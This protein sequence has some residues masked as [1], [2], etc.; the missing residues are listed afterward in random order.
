MS[1][2]IA[3]IA[4]KV[5]TSTATISRALNG[6]PGVSTELRAKILHAAKEM[7]YLPNISARGLIT[8]KTKIAA[9]VVEAKHA[10]SADPFY[11]S[12]LQGIQTELA[13]NSYHVILVGYNNEEENGQVWQ[14]AREQK[15]DGFIFAGPDINVATILAI[16][17]AGYPVV[18]VD[19][20]LPGTKISSISID[21]LGGAF[22][23]V[24]HLI[25]HGHKKITFL[26]GASGWASTR[27]RLDGY[28]TALR[29]NG[30]DP[31][32]KPLF[33][34]ATT[35]ETG[36]S[37]MIS[38]L[39]GEVRPTAVFAVNDA[40]AIGAM[41]AIHEAGLQ[42]PEDIAVAGFDDVIWS[43]YSDP[44]LT[45]ASVFKEKLGNQAG[46]H[47]LELIESPDEPPVKIEVSTQ[48]VIRR[49][50][51]CRGDRSS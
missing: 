30:I 6:L 26:G 2:T 9:F 5:G 21:N 43:A 20:S 35:I 27:E 24:E 23:V 48:L 51:G 37:G 44:P 16:K 1:V 39:G 13:K 18:L 31:S 36:Y 50:C 15:A 49:S 42:V 28:E 12:I 8:K 19:N 34:P 17:E 25:E 3:E 38:I 40:M 11:P 45:T 33:M 46:H 29:Q 7:D 4:K 32:L 10:N 22:E 14:I 47:F 41:K